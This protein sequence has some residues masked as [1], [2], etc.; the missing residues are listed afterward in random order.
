[1]LRVT[2]NPTYAETS[3]NTAAAP[4]PEPFQ[5]FDEYKSYAQVETC[6]EQVLFDKV[7]EPKL[8]EHPTKNSCQTELQL[9]RVAFNS[10][11]KRNS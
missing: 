7:S 9:V 3:R 5:M 11:V 2:G 10:P 1:M 4:R 6:V 8:R